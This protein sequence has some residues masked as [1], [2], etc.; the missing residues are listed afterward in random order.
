MKTPVLCSN[1]SR[2]L[3]LWVGRTVRR[4]L[5]FAQTRFLRLGL[6]FLTLAAIG[7][8]LSQP[9]SAGVYLLFPLLLVSFFEGPQL[10]G[11]LSFLFLLMLACIGTSPWEM[12]ILVPLFLFAVSLA[13]I[14]ASKYC[15][16]YQH[17][18]RLI[19][20]LELAREVQRTMEPPTS[21]LLGG[22]HMQ[23][24]MEICQELGGDF[25][26]ARR[27]PDGG[28]LV[29][30]GDVQGKGPQSALTAAYLEGV[31]HHSCVSGMTSP[32]EVLKSMH[33]LLENKDG[34]RFVTAMCLRSDG[35]GRH[36]RIANAGHPLPILFDEVAR[37]VGQTGVVLGIMGVFELGIADVEMNESQRML[38]LSDGCYE[39]EEVS[40]SLQAL[41]H[42]KSSLDEI[43]DWIQD[44]NLNLHD[45]RTVVLLQHNSSG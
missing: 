4:E 1:Y 30:V 14:T 38:I 35:D 32:E 36:W 45:D 8:S 20:R 44:S 26:A 42:P 29:V 5:T 15:H 40:E 18:K 27:L 23:T 9:A 21:L 33:H 28:A 3:D 6:C 43:L 7:G 2:L 31:F 11:R 39:E 13:G 10:G 17:R 24:R 34:G 16:L 37:R 41:L 12:L 25:V 22:V 19:K